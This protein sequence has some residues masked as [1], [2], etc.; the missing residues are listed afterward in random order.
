MSSLVVFSLLTAALPPAARIAHAATSLRADAV[1]LVNSA[2]AGYLDFQRYI[3]PYLNHFGVPY[4][5]LDI[6]AASVTSA[7]GDYAL[8]IIGHRQ[9]DTAGIYLDNVEQA[10]IPAVPPPTHA[11]ELKAMREV[12][13]PGQRSIEEVSAFLGLPPDRFIKTLMV[14]T[15]G[16]EP[17]AVLVRGDHTLSE[18]KLVR[19][20]GVAAV[21]MADAA[22]VEKVTGAAT[23]PTG[24]MTIAYKWGRSGGGF[25]G[26]MYVDATK[27]TA[28][29]EPSSLL[30]LMT[31]GIGLARL[32]LRRR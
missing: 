15:D 6:N 17:V 13:T 14:V 24:F 10:A 19:V 26:S 18:A 30:A 20:L 12:A 27:L 16:G 7:I 28:V 21:T 31:G 5:T 29:P 4:T 32:A 11:G 25:N 23:S 2:S 8:I 9:L 3:Q 1:V 22:T